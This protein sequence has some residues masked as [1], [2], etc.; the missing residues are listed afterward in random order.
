MLM[1]KSTTGNNR[2]GFTMIELLVVLAILLI[3]GGIVALAIPPALCEARLRAST[4]AVIAQLQFAR[5][6]AVANQ[7]EAAVEFDGQ[8]NGSA[9]VMDAPDRDG[10]S[11]WQAVTTPAGRYRSFPDGI[12]INSVSVNNTGDTPS[13]L[14]V[15]PVNSKPESNKTYSRADA[16]YV[17]FSALGQA[18]AATIVLQ[19]AQGA[20]RTLQV[21]ALT[22]R[23]DVVDKNGVV[24][25][26]Q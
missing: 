8:D 5:S 9:V 18:E 6:Y 4:L 13:G 3:M 20:Q 1:L 24:S 2:R 21:D 23:C 25:S 11:V 17:T 16:Q 10:N 19:D 26:N 7:T 14:V 15:A 22:G 12:A